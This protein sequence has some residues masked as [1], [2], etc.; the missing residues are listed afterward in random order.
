MDNEFTI[1]DNIS[2]DNS[3]NQRKLAERTGLSLG[4]VNILI[5]RLINK[6][7]L[8]VEHLSSK[9]I[10]YF[11]TPAGII[12][13]A[14]RT[15]Q[16]IVYS[17]NYIRDLNNKI[18]DILQHEKTCDN[19]YLY[20]EKNEVYQ[21]IKNA[22]DDLKVAYVL[23]DTDMIQGKDPNK[24]CLVLV[25]DSEKYEMMKEKGARCVNILEV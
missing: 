7:L 19:I 10:K 11:L 24:D 18:K 4:A 20:G 16:Y 2:K 3:I 15:Y 14:E 8:K 25:W 1:L 23:L 17:Y 22:M 9:S 21:I 6:G 5:K 13:K 12:A